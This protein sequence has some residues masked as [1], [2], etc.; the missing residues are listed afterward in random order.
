MLLSSNDL[1]NRVAGSV[2]NV[3]VYCDKSGKYRHSV[4]PS[5]KPCMNTGTEKTGCP[6]GSSLTPLGDDKGSIYLTKTTII[7][8][9]RILLHIRLFE[10]STKMRPSKTRFWI[11][12][13]TTLR[14]DKASLGWPTNIRGFRSLANISTVFGLPHGSK[15]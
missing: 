14:P 15:R 2:N 6:F 8:P 12:K 5:D 11:T 1:Q 13:R 7:L 4:A 10:R 9:Q 3:W